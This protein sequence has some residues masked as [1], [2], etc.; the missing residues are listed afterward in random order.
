MLS[1][2]GASDYTSAYNNANMYYKSSDAFEEEL[3]AFLAANADRTCLVPENSPEDGNG[4]YR[5]AEWIARRL[6]EKTG[7]RGEIEPFERDVYMDTFK[8]QNVV[9]S[10]KSPAENN[11]EGKRV[12]I[13]AHYDNM[14]TRCET[15]NGAGYYFTGTRAEG[16]MDNGAAVAVMLVMCEY[17][18]KNAAA[19]ETDIDFVFY[20]MGCIDYGGADEYF[21]GLSSEERQNVLM[22]ATLTKLGGD[23]LW[24]YFDEQPTEHGDFIMGVAQKDGYGE[25][26]SEPP[27][28]QADPDAIYTDQLPYTPYSLMNESSVYFGK[29]NVCSVTTGSDST[30]LLYD[31]DGYGRENISGTTSDTLAALK[32]ANPGY[33]DQLLITAE[34]LTRSIMCGGFTQACETSLENIGSYRWM[35]SRLAAYITGGVLAAGVLIFTILMTKHLRKKYADTDVKRNIKVAVFGMDYEK[36]E[37]GDI[38]VDINPGKHV[39]D[40]PF[41]DDPFDTGEDKKQ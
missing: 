14:Y 34:V 1:G 16:A 7:V 30:F 23:K 15:A 31:Q 12:V 24:F 11:P 9:Y 41:G 10:V 3:N 29:T 39:P 19:L 33:A 6:E 18:Q 21:Y 27:V 20:G 17:F 36:P 5:A 4:E 35:T 22:A 2:C 40:D 13:G 37:D 8:S 38:Y 25:Y 26:I 32:S 28:A